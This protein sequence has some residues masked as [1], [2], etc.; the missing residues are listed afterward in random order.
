VYLIGVIIFQQ[1]RRSW[2]WPVINKPSCTVRMPIFYWRIWSSFSCKASLIKWNNICQ[3]Y[4]F[5]QHLKTGKFFPFTKN[6]PL[7]LRFS[8]L[9]VNGKQM[10]LA[11]YYYKKALKDWI[12]CLS[13]NPT[14]PVTSW[15]KY[16]IIIRL[17]TSA[18]CV[19]LSILLLTQCLC[20]IFGIL[21]SCRWIFTFGSIGGWPP[22]EL[23]YQWLP[24]LTRN[25]AANSSVQNPVFS[26]CLNSLW[27]VRT[28]NTFSYLF[29]ILCSYR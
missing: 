1:L 15:I 18:N 7:T 12:F 28:N 27:L 24:L 22:F 25:G 20:Q 8:V 4:C 13:L 10:L 29:F 16:S 3:S 11:Y 2:F 21:C 26:L 23:R 14:M 17:F 6:S 9:L 5:L 19:S